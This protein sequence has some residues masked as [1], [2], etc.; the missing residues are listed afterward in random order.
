MTVILV[1]VAAVA[2]CCG[3]DLNCGQVYGVGSF[4]LTVE[5][6]SATPIQAVSYSNGDFGESL[7]WMA[8]E[9]VD[10]ELFDYRRADDFDGKR[11]IASITFTGTASIIG[12]E[13]SYRHQGQLA[14]LIEFEDGRQK[15]KV[16]DIPAGRGPRSIVVAVE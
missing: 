4:D 11:F 14:L 13:R 12:F 6:R 16:V 5:L 7:H 15:C 8:E 1:C 2:I 10:P 3:I 9:R